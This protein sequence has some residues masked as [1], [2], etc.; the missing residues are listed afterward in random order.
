[1]H[2]HL[3][4]DHLH[5][6][7]LE[8]DERHGFVLLF[9]AHSWVHHLHWMVLF[10]DGWLPYAPLRPAMFGP[11]LTFMPKRYRKRGRFPNLQCRIRRTSGHVRIIK[12][13]PG[14]RVT[15]I[16]TRRS[17]ASQRRVE[18]ELAALG[19]TTPNT[20]AVEHHNSTAQRM[21]PHEVYRS[22]CVLETSSC[23]PVRR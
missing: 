3:A 12:M 21:N 8:A 22:H 7:S 19:Y 11:P 1:M 6:T 5:V 20:S 15:D 4:Q 18:Q 14:K 9:G 13:Y 2:D 23:L 10:T 17:T 16:R